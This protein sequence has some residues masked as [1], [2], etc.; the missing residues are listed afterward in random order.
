MI[1]TLIFFQGAWG[2]G[3]KG[4]DWICQAATYVVQEEGLR[5]LLKF[6]P[7]VMGHL[8]NVP[9]IYWKDL[10]EEVKKIGRPSHYLDIEVF[11]GKPRDIP[12]SYSEMKSKFENFPS[13]ASGVA[14][15][16]FHSE[17]GSLWW[18]LQQFVDRAV[19]LKTKIH[20]PAPSGPKETQD[21]NYPY[22]QAIFAMMVNMGLMGHFIGDASMPLHHSFDHDAQRAGHAGLHSYYEDFTISELPA[23]A[24]LEIIKLAKKMRAQKKEAF[25]V[26]DTAFDNIREL[27]LKSFSEISQLIA[28]DQL[29]TKG[30][31]T[32]KPVR[33]PFEKTKKKFAALSVQEL[34]RSVA[35]LSLT[36]DQI[37]QKLDRP[38]LSAYKSFQY[39][40]QPEFVDPDYF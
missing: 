15:K 7:Q 28:A 8:C 38:D 16:D 10:P 9:D 21:Y 24:F 18:R 12:R 31:E 30:T 4:H 27:S 39:P 33:M 3:G 22:N 26:K 2:W 6:K 14:F 20:S 1:W 17:T 5:N 32:Q 23:S 29:K 11:Q 19:A 13:P 34:S 25:L 35:L 36:W 37:Y 40:F